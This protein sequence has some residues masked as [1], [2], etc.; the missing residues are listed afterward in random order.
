MVNLKSDGIGLKCTRANDVFEYHTVCGDVYSLGL[1]NGFLYISHDVGISK[2]NTISNS[3]ILRVGALNEPCVL[4][5]FGASGAFFTNEKKFAIFESKP[6]AEKESQQG[7]ITGPASSC[8]FMQPV[9]ICTEF[10]SVIFVCEPHA[11]SVRIISKMQECA[12]FLKKLSFHCKAFSVH[13]RGAS[14]P[15]KSLPEVVVVL[16]EQCRESLDAMETKI[17]SETNF[18]ATLNGAEGSVSAKTMKSVKL[19]EWALRCLNYITGEL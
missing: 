13:T 14:Y 11:N 1:N 10:N 18:T 8:R 4:T 9:G 19:M 17:W 5:P 3:H 16:V 6:S 12:S 7:N 2:V 15:I